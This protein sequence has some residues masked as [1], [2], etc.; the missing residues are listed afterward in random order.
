MILGESAP[1]PAPGGATTGYLVNTGEGWFL[2]DC[3]SGILAELLRHISLSELKGVIITHYHADHIADL[4]VLQYAIMVERMQGKRKDFLLV[5]ANQDPIVKFKEVSYLDHVQAIPIRADSQISLCGATVTFA[6]T[7]HAVP[8]LAVSI[9]YQNRKLVFSGDTGPS[10]RVE[11]LAREADLFVCEATWLE[12]DQ[13][14]ASIGHLTTRQAAEMAI[15][16]NVKSL[17]LTHIFPGYDRIQ[18]R[19]EA[20]AVFGQNVLLASKG[21]ILEI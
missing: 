3:G 10:Q 18:L 20:E 15:R 6:N 7:H 16:A 14:S 9:E 8:C 19:Q 1:Y 11:E 21:L 4:G 5:Y 17:C 12:K 2:I 13:G